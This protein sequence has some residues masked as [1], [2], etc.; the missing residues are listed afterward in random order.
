MSKRGAEELAEAPDPKKREIKTVRLPSGEMNE[1]PRSVYVEEMQKHWGIPGGSGE[2]PFNSCVTYRV[3]HTIS[4]VMATGPDG[5]N[6]IHPDT[7]GSDADPNLCGHAEWGSGWKPGSVI[8]IPK[9]FVVKK[10]EL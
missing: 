7:A 9:E 3:R 8:Q 1:I 5:K 4:I 10:E 2:E 6:W